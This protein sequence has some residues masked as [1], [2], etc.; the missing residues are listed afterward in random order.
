MLSNIFQDFPNQGS[1]L[2]CG[3][4]TI[5]KLHT[6]LLL[7][8]KKPSILFW[9]ALS[10]SRNILAGHYVKI[11]RIRDFSGPYFHTFGFSTE[12]YSVNRHIQ[13]ECGKIRTRKTPHTDTYYA[14]RESRKN[15][16]AATKFKMPQKNYNGNISNSGSDNKMT[17]AGMFLDSLR[18]T[19]RTFTRDV[20]KTM[21]NIYNGSFLQK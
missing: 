4:L 11:V 2:V 21:S 14:V 6:L 3:N 10:L 19:L 15:S 17:S 20:F 16:Y 13:C 1:E 5:S 7:C 8:L 12:I 18:L 9:E